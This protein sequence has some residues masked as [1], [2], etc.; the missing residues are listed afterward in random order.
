MVGMRPSCGRLIPAAAALCVAITV[1][2]APAA[3]ARAPSTSRAGSASTAGK[4]ESS[5]LSKMVP[6]SHRTS[7]SDLTYAQR[8]A[9]AGQVLVGD[10]QA[11]ARAKSRAERAGGSRAS[12]R[13][14]LQAPSSLRN[15]QG[16]NDTNVAPS[17]STSAIGTQRYV[18]LVNSKIG[19]WNR[20][21]DTPLATD[22]LASL[23]GA[24]SGPSVFDPQVIWDPDTNRFYYAADVV[25]SATQNLLAFGFST[26]A[27]PNNA[28]TDWCEFAVDY[29]ATFPD[30]PKLG[31]F[32]G[33]MLIGANVF[34]SNASSAT[35]VRSDVVGI[36]KPGSGTTC[37]A[38]NTFTVSIAQNLHNADASQSTTP[39]PANQVDGNATG[40][41]LAG[42]GFTGGN[43]VTVFNVTKNSSNQIVV[44]APRAMSVA[45]FAVPAPAP[46]PGTT[47]MLDTLDAR[48][49][50]AV[51]AVDPFRSSQVAIFTQHTVNGSG[52]RS[53][54]RWYEI[55]PTPSIP[56]PFQS[57]TQSSASLFLYNAAI[58]PD[59][60]R[61]GAS[62]QFGNGFLL[63]YSRS[64]TNAKIS[65]ASASKVN[66]GSVTGELV[67]KTSPDVIDDGSCRGGVC[68]WG[69]Y[70]GA[71]PDPASNTTASNGVVWAVNA[72]A[73]ASSGTSAD[74][75]TQNFALRVSPK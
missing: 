25:V 15:F 23:T 35:F 56:V 6:S 1:T 69:D 13:V 8:A 17:D 73:Q 14:G 21:S 62:G 36:T 63:Q 61:N 18:E 10:E 34:S 24:G 41:V 55:N 52:G 27:S 7:P 48:F 11:Y 33:M 47:R 20:T 22:T 38:A 74:W 72:W 5:R 68:R 53:V 39:L 12:T 70:A 64:S 3:S 75:R 50:N 57:G 28:T 31:D 37:P 4:T 43:F 60:R 16:V 51:E 9:I 66:N 59:R 26:T 54:V 71:S 40:H 67:L 58:S 44:A 46:Q 29:G 65:I 19:I 45:A 32:S 49:T 2:A 42:K 30:Y